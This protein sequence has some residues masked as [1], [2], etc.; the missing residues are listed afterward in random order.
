[1]DAP[2]LKRA[3]KSLPAV[4][5]IAR[6]VSR[7]R[8]PIVPFAGAVHRAGIRVGQR[9][10]LVSAFSTDLSG[11]L[12]AACPNGIDVYFE[13][14]GGAVLDKVLPLLNAGARVLL[15]WTASDHLIRAASDV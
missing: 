3:G 1:L 2:I 9:D 4:C 10:L 14:A 5:G 11:Q 8:Q 6:R 13:A 15:G 12:A 7:S